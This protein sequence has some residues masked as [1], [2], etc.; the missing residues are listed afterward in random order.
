MTDVSDLDIM[1]REALDL[2][3]ARPA[4]YRRREVR[5]ALVQLAEAVLGYAADPP[6]CGCGG[7]HWSCPG[8]DGYSESL[9][10]EDARNAWQGV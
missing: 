10:K 8:E 9:A 1:A 3:N 2:V 5:T 4:A 6:E 7:Y